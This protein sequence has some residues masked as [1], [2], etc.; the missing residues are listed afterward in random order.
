MLAS[1]DQND[2]NFLSMK[3]FFTGFP[4]F[5]GK[6]LAHT[7][8]EQHPDIQF[9]FLDHP[10]QLIKANDDFRSLNL[11][12]KRHEIIPGDITNK[13]LGI[14]D[15]ALIRRIQTEVQMVFHL[16]AIYDLTVPEKVAKRVNVQG[17]ENILN[18]FSSSPAL[19]R[20]NHISTCYVSGDQKGLITPDKLEEGQSFHNFYESTKHESEVLVKHRMNQMPITIFRPAI[21]VGHSKTGETDKFDGPYVVMK[22]LHRIRYLLR[23][24]PN[25]GF[26]N[27]EVNTVPVD[28]VCQVM[29]YLAFQE[30]SKGKTYQ[31]SDQN[32]PTTEDF[33]GFIVKL[34]GGIAPFHFSALKNIILKILKIP[35]V[36]KIT[37]ITGQHLDYFTHEGQYRD[38]NLLNDLKGANIRPLKYTDFYPQLYDF[39]KNRAFH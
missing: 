12:F 21:V 16:A 3:V 10:T 18:F 24:V 5:I 15:P 8:L 39:M 1:H 14:E 7:L 9:L 6:Y 29:G 36:A 4:G 27:C 26:K 20:F 17:T 37:Q 32:P 34:I 38:P 35:Q 25:L 19:R 28:Y 33:F 13:Q 22:F 30:K 11:D 2:Y 31:I 23:L